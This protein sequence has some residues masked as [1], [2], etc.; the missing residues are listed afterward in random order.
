[1]TGKADVSD[2]R[3]RIVERIGLALVR[4]RAAMVLA[5]DRRH[6]G[7]SGSD[8]LAV[9]VIMLLAT[10]LRAI[11]A[12]TWLGFAVDGALG[13]RAFV[14]TLSDALVLVLGFLVIAAAIIYVATG[15]RR[16]VGRSFDLA[17]VAALPLLFVDLGASVVVHAAELRVP[18]T[19]KGT[20][21]GIS[22]AW[23]AALV[24]LAAIEARRAP[25]SPIGALAVPRRAGWGIAA[26]ALAGMGVQISWL[27]RHADHVR[28]MTPGDPAPDFTLPRIAGPDRLG[29]SLSLSETRGKI[30]VVDFWAT[31]CGPCLKAMPKLDALGRRD[32]DIVVIAINI[33][34]SNE[35]FALFD[36][37]KYAMTLLAGD[38]VTSERYGVAAI[39]HTVVIDRAGHVRRVFRGGT[40]GLERE[41]SALLK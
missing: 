10:Q 4:P 3:T 21:S 40:S 36:E 27:A 33:D 29:P 30:V 5:S 17:C 14:H 23:A 22:Y 39:P 9:I 38:R 24:A 25:P 37:R 32:P 19:I 7:R 8:L 20:L 15:A 28:P 31:W 26:I 41:V 11:I 35:A 16:E 6:T 34:D 12:A 2:E 13:V 1:V 18:P